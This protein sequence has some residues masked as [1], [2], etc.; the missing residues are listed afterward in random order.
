MANDR[1]FFAVK[2][3]GIAQD[4][5]LTF[6]EIHGLQSI[7]VSTNYNLEP[8]QEIGQL[9]IYENVEDIPDVQITMQK[10]L[11]GYPLIYHLLTRGATDPTLV[12]RSKIK[13]IVGLS[14]FDDTKESA[15]GQPLSEMHASGQFPQSLTYTFPVEGNFIEDVTTVGNDK[16][17]VN[18]PNCTS[19]PTSFSFTGQFT[20]TDS[21][22]SISNSG[23]VNRREDFIMNAATGSAV[24]SNGASTEIENSV[25]PLDIF[26][27]ASDGTNGSR[28]VHFQNITV[29]T[30]LGRDEIFELGAL[31]PY[32]RYVNFPVDVTTDFEV[33]SVS[34]DMVSATAAGCIAGGV[35]GAGSN[36]TEQ[37]IRLVA[38]EGTRIYLGT[39][40]KLQSIDMGGGNADGGNDTIT[41]SYNN[42]SKMTVMHELDPDGS[43]R[44]DAVGA[45]YLKN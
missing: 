43:L 30:D 9:E 33:I 36:L 6:T 10:V 12:G 1:V 32:T 13:S 25:F 34:G 45:T 27:I 22:L 37:T 42:T 28:K 23:G 26:G 40:N 41:Y 4:G 21:P 5:T 20:G 18:D 16:V 39:K 31:D 44:V 17:W 7:G 8:V 2:Q 14:I 38:C 11:D 24:D 19:A 29:S 15:T 35:C 3:G